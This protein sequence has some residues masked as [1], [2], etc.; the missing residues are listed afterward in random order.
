MAEHGL[1]IIE[2]EC[3]AC[4]KMLLRRSNSELEV[5]A[6]LVTHVRSCTLQLQDFAL[7]DFA[8]KH[9]LHLQGMRTME[10]DIRTGSVSLCIVINFSDSLT[11]TLFL[12]NHKSR[13][14]PKHVTILS[15]LPTYLR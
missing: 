5:K 2:V 13:G 6:Y 9:C 10:D 11:T 15:F 8:W 14:V 1:R 4:S 7:E 12:P 3:V